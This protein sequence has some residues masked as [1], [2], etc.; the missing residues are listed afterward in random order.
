MTRH[1]TLTCCVDYASS[2]EPNTPKTAVIDTKYLIS[3][4]DRDVNRV[5]AML[6]APQ[7]CTIVEFPHS[8][9]AS[10]SS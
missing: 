4:R 2:T 3:S 7:T 9:Y 8:E 1:S 5:Y 10:S 6:E